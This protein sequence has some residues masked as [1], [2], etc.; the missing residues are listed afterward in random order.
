MVDMSSDF[1]LKYFIF[2][3]KIIGF[4]CITIFIQFYIADLPARYL[5]S[6]FA[7]D[8]NE[9]DKYTAAQAEVVELG[10]HTILRGWRAKARA[11]SSPAFG[12][13]SCP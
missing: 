3:F 2:L 4:Y 12:T 10:R 6:S 1:Y 7:L 9:F 13:K 11:G 5:S 8:D